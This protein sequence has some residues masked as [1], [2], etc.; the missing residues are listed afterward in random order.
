MAF[1]PAFQNY[2]FDFRP[3]YLSRHIRFFQPAKTEILKL[4]TVV[5][6]FM[7]EIFSGENSNWWK[8]MIL[9]YCLYSIGS[10]MT[11]SPADIKPL[12][13]DSLSSHYCVYFQYIYTLGRKFC[14]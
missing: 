4:P 13:G 6:Q 10:S 9:I 11:L 5:S 12:A 2:I 7:H 1:A 3:A 8:I 14:H